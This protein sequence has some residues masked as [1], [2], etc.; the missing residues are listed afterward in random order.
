V[1]ETYG[2]SGAGALRVLQ[3]RWGFPLDQAKRILEIA[4]THTHDAE[5]V[6]GGILHIRYRGNVS[7]RKG[8]RLYELEADV[9]DEAEQ[10]RFDRQRKGLPSGTRKVYTQEEAM[11]SRYSSGKATTRQRSRKGREM[12]PRKNTKTAAPE[13]ETTAANGEGDL[14]TA[15]EKAMNKDHF[16]PTQ[17][18]YLN[19]FAENVVDPNELAED[20]DRLM[21]MTLQFYG[22]FQRS[23]FNREQREARAAE[24]AKAAPADEPEEPA[25]PARGRG[26]T[27]ATAKAT[28]KAPA[29]TAKAGPTRRTR[30]TR[31]AATSTPY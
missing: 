5:P 29:S 3:E 13:P 1:S 21:I 27:T 17:E 7:G 20:L 15:V 24:R 2:I 14:A 8:H 6:K 22:P 4:R 25:K 16:S 18:D 9:M 23:D 11:P 26:R 12:P 30:G 28:A 31:A 19:W 10:A